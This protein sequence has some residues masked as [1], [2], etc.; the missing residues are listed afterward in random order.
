MMII[1]VIL[2]V[3][4]LLSVIGN[5]VSLAN[6]LK[7]KIKLLLVWFA[8]IPEEAIRQCKFCHLQLA[9]PSQACQP[10]PCS[11]L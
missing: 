6:P 2:I 3:R 7:N 1:V 9:S 11:I 8:G 10:N 5:N 4:Q